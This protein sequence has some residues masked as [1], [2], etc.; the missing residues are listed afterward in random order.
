M[1]SLLPTLDIWFQVWKVH[2]LAS[3]WNY[4]TRHL[5]K[6]WWHTEMYSV[7]QIQL[8]HGT[9]IVDTTGLAIQRDAFWPGRPRFQWRQ[10]KVERQLC[11]QTTLLSTRFNAKLPISKNTF[12]FRLLTSG[13]QWFSARHDATKTYSVNKVNSNTSICYQ[14]VFAV[15]ALVLVGQLRIGIIGKGVAKPFDYTCRNANF[16]RDWHICK[17]R[18]RTLTW[19]KTY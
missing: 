10:L 15:T 8:C 18:L 17:F 4:Q 1:S 13:Q 11:T 9:Y 12:R 2:W 3:L 14:I 19:N 6:S 7:N 5:V 16:C